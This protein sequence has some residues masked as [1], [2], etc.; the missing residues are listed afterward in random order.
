MPPNGTSKPLKLQFGLVNHEYQY[1]TAETFG[2]KVNASA[3]TMKKKQLWTLEHGDQDGN[4]VFLRSS[5]GRY[6]S[7]NKD[8]D[9]ICE[10]D[11]PNNNCRFL[12]I[13]QPNGRW[14]LQSEPFQRYLGGSSDRVT[15]FAQTFGDPELWAIHLA[16]HPQASLLSASRKRYAR[17]S[18]SG[19]EISFISNIPWGVGS[20]I[21]LV[22]MAGKYCLKTCD[23]RFLSSSGN[24]VN[25]SGP[26]TE[27]TLV[28]RSSMLAFKD[29]MGKYLTPSGPTGTLKS[30]K[31][32]KP[33]KD[34]LF[35]IEESRPQVVFV[36]A[37]KR[38]VSTRQ[39][40]CRSLL[41]NTHSLHTHCK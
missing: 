7:T 5:L 32:T 28:L 15:C 13:A 29:N 36:G 35:D 33:T 4:V 30:G 17:L 1:L 24:L 11:V 3:T 31:C 14:A 26:D 34:E 9:V 22:F 38:F 19:T 40:N 37:N 2:F 23:N 10:Q 21:T 12:L 20:L 27:Y 25:E 18:A 41:L 6:L 39:G 16:H 8:G